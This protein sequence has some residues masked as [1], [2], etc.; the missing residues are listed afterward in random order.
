[1][2]GRRKW[3]WILAVIFAGALAVS[4]IFF[5]HRQEEEP[6]GTLVSTQMR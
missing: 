5:S 3:I 4:L 6:G 1:M 2:A